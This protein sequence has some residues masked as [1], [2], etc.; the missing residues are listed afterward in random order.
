MQLQD[1]VAAGA[2]GDAE[3]VIGALPGILRGI[4]EKQLRVVPLVEA[5]VAGSEDLKKA[6][7]RRRARMAEE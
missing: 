2:R 7:E 1:G 5:L 6:A 4:G 3:K